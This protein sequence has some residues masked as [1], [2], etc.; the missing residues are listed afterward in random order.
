LGV[1]SFLNV[2]ENDELALDFALDHLAYFSLGEAGLA[3]QTPVY[4]SSFLP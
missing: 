4:G 1:E 2:K 3:I